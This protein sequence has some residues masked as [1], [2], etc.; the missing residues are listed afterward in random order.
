[1]FAAGNTMGRSGA[2]DTAGPMDVRV[3]LGSGVKSL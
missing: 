2:D 1:M 3:A